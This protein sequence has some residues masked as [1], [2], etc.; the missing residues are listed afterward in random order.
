[1]DGTLA[2]G[3]T[4]HERRYGTTSLRFSL[5][6]EAQMFLSN[7]KERT[8][9]SEKTSTSQ[10]RGPLFF[11][12][13]ITQLLFSKNQKGRKLLQAWN[14][15]FHKDFFSTTPYGLQDRIWKLE[16]LF[17]EEKGIT[18]NPRRLKKPKSTCHRTLEGLGFWNLVENGPPLLSSDSKNSLLGSNQL[19]PLGTARPLQNQSQ[20][21]EIQRITRPLR[22]RSHSLCH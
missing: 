1:L 13:N 3:T 10:S 14:R 17:Q 9:N 18:N 6:D 8:E 2:E 12:N 20:N 5:P 22:A 19:L 11:I 7:R 4:N 21:H 15:N 16:A